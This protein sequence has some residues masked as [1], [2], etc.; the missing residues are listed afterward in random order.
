MIDLAELSDAFTILSSSWSAWI[1]VIP[2]S[3]VGAVL[4]RHAGHFNHDGHGH[5]PAHDA[6]YGFPAS[7]HLSDVDLHR[8]RVWWVCSGHLDE[9]S[10]AH[11]LPL[12]QPLM[13]IPCLGKVATM[14]RWELR[15]P[16]LS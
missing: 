11:P 3:A 1:F 7:D 6:L 13:A 14:R 8:R 9:H 15:L 12:R 16:H 4:R 5:L 10:P 2:R